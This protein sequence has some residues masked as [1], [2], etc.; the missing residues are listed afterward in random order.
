MD[1]S[2]ELL[3]WIG[4]ILGAIGFLINLLLILLAFAL[5]HR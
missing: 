1:R 4:T 5:G 3:T 2:G